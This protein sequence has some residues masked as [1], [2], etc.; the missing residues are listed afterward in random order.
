METKLSLILQLRV[1]VWQKNNVRSMA[2][3]NVLTKTFWSPGDALSEENKNEVRKGQSWNLQCA[4]IWPKLEHNVNS[5][6]INAT[7]T[8]EQKTAGYCTKLKA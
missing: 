6:W 2:N 3:E 7:H 1:I 5:I 8:Y 4:Q